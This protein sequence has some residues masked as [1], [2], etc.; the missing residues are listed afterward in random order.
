[1]ISW[2]LLSV[3]QSHFGK[4]QNEGVVILAIYSGH[5]GKNE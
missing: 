3:W 1:M 5:F 2:D 4:S